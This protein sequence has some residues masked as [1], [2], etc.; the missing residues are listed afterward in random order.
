MDVIGGFAQSQ[1]GSFSEIFQNERQHKEQMYWIKRN[2]NQDT[3]SLL[4][5]V[6]DHSKTEIRSHYQTYINLIDTPMLVLSLIW[7]FGLN[8]FQFSDPFVPGL[9]DTGDCPECIE[10]RRPWIIYAWVFFLTVVLVLPFWGILMLIR[11]KLKL[12]S[13]Q[14]ESLAGI[15]W[16]K[17]EA[18]RRVDD[19]AHSVEN[20]ECHG[21]SAEA[22]SITTPKIA[23]ELIKDVTKYQEKW[24]TQWDNECSWL[25]R[26]STTL[27]WMSAG[28]ALILVTLSMVVFFSDKGGV[29]PDYAPYFAAFMASG[30]VLPSVYVLQQ[31]AVNKVKEPKMHKRR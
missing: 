25:V 10:A 3:H 4:L 5:D 23:L 6:I 20:M 31:E 11:C 13:W 24:R 22:R 1:L 8:T 7:P 9:A 14:Q 12:D 15:K 18:L 21:S 19:I 17:D 28:G 2:Y 27:L 30:C 29:Y 16:H 26:A